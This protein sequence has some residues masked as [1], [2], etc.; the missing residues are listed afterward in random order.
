VGIGQQPQVDKN[1]DLLFT[2]MRENRAD[3]GDISYY[4]SIIFDPR[5]GAQSQSAGLHWTE[6]PFF[7][8]I[9][10]RDTGAIPHAEGTTDLF[11]GRLSV[12]HIAWGDTVFSIAQRFDLKPVELV[13]LNPQL[14][15]ISPTPRAGESLNLDPQAR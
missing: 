5:A 6:S 3:R 1:G 13:F 15:Y 14:G 11:G 7:T 9:T 12:Y 8:G 4:N 10:P 2:I